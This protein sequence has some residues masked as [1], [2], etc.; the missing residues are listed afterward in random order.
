MARRAELRER[1]RRLFFQRDAKA[2]GHPIQGAAVD[3]QDFRGACSIPLGSVKHVH[4]V[5]TLE[6]VECRQ[7]GKRLILRRGTGGGSRR[8]I[9][10]EGLDQRTSARDDQALDRVSELPHVA[11]PRMAQEGIDRLRRQ[12]L[13]L[14]RAFACVIEEA[15]NQQ[16]DIR[17][18]RMTITLSL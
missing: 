5:A 2:F 18:T 13:L 8:V 12:D 16:R 6:V 9:E 17:P 11:R 14:P 1:H 4:E 15:A 10:I 7:T 3:A